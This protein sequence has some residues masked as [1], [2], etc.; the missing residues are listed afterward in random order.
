MR[1]LEIADVDTV[2]VDG[3]NAVPGTVVQRLKDAGFDLGREIIYTY[4][5]CRGTTVLMQYP[6]PQHPLQ[7]QYRH[8]L[9]GGS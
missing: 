9:P 4:D 6:A 7:A 2:A 3:V 1:M 8:L 5:G